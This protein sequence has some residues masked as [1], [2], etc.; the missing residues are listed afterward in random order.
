MT[1]PLLEAEDL[2]RSAARDDFLDGD[3]LTPIEQQQIQQIEEKGSR[4]STV[5]AVALALGASFLLYR[6]Y[7]RRKLLG[8]VSPSWTVEALDLAVGAAWAV[9]VPKWVRMVTPTIMNAYLMGVREAQLGNVPPEVLERAAQE[10]ARSLGEYMNTT[11]S[12]ALQEGFNSYLNRKMTRRMAAEKVITAVGLNPRQ[13]RSVVS[14][15]QLGEKPVTSI[16]ERSIDAKMGRHIDTLLLGRA[17]QMGENEAFAATKQG[18]QLT[19]MWMIQKGRLPKTA[20]KEWVTARDERVCAYCGPM[21]S[22]RASVNEPF[23]TELGEVWMP[24]LHPSCRCEV[25]LRLNTAALFSKAYEEEEHPRAQDGRFKNK[26]DKA[27]PR[28]KYGD[29]DPDTQRILRETFLRSMGEEQTKLPELPKLPTLPTLGGSLAGQ[30]KL[31]STA[32]LG[33]P[34][35]EEQTTLGQP[36]LAE[37]TLTGAQLKK[38]KLSFSQHLAQQ[39]GKLGSPVLHTIAQTAERQGRQARREKSLQSVT[40][41]PPADDVIRVEPIEGIYVFQEEKEF[42]HPS[43]ESGSIRRFHQND[44]HEEEDRM[45]DEVNEKWDNT[46]DDI[47][48]ELHGEQVPVEDTGGN[49]IVATMDEDTLVAAYEAISI[50]DPNK[51]VHVNGIAPTGEAHYEVPVASGALAEAL[52]L[53]PSEFM[54]VVYRVFELHTESLDY[55]LPGRVSGT[56]VSNGDYEIVGEVQLKRTPAGLPYKE[57]MVVPVKSPGTPMDLSQYDRGD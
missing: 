12:Q 16:I 34:E 4:A 21:H 37:S 2:F 20:E 29:L 6:R 13:M 52:K 17:Q 3:E 56:L 41:R 11:S 8:E 33:S 36:K 31:A 22:K 27:R 51:R 25:K 7:M 49:I 32:K 38:P 30:A 14:A 46:F 9:F 23:K 18:K 50:G 5:A 24:S 35:G 39:Q 15:E 54:P 42:Y 55:T 26:P 44:V 40:Q 1:Q 10:Y 48:H 43:Y 57:I 47:F 53:N 45:H 28:V 19:W